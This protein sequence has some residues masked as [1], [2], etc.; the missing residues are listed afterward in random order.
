VEE[1]DNSDKVSNIELARSYEVQAAQ[2]VDDQQ[3]LAFYRKAAAAYNYL[4]AYHEEARCLSLTCDLLKGEAKVDCLV[5][6]W[7]ICIKAITV[8]KYETSFEWKGEDEN[9][10][11]RYKE[12]LSMYYNGALD[13][14]DN[15]LKI[16]DVDKEKLLER[17]Y[18][19][20]V[21]RRND[22]GWGESECFSSID[23]SFKKRSR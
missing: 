14:L 23:E 7:G 19:E 3:K 6:I 20:C 2:A 5:S 13:A 15:A 11:P 18:A 10:D 22:G 9:L 1:S 12:I 17:L 4:G 16:A 8:Y 21:K